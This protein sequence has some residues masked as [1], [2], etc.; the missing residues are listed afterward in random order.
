MDRQRIKSTSR[1]SATCSDVVLRGG[2]ETDS[3][4]LVFRPELVDNPHDNNAAVRG[5]FIYQ[6]K[7]KAKE[8]EDTREASLASLKSGEGY[9]LEL[10]AAEVFKLCGYLNELYKIFKKDGIPYGETE[11]VRLDSVVGQ[12]VQIPHP[13]LKA[14]LTAHQAMGEELLASLLVWAADAEDPAPLISRLIA[15]GESALRNLN[16]ATGLGTLKTALAIW[17]ENKLNSQEEF[18]QK[19]LTEHSFVL[20]QVFSWPMTIVKEKAY[21]GGKTV[22]NEGGNIVDFLVKNFLTKNAA[23][24]EIKTPNTA[25]LGRKYRNTFNLSEDLSGSV[26]QVLNYRSSLQRHYANIATGRARYE[27]F[28][29]KCV[30]IIG[31]VGAI[32]NDP[33]KI[34]ALELYRSSC[35]SVTV[36]T[37]DEL[38]AKTERLITV[39]ETA[40]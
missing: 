2:K 25:L 9:K 13:Q 38:F 39:L 23:L 22:L 4:R 35:S 20:E 6:K 17:K 36:I 11:Y 27:A 32:R 18:W 3:I 16:V 24:V 40:T 1:S 12:L 21:V 7:G 19:S 8:W 33:D 29:P 37:F 26:M 31:N 30:L 5:T 14:Y 10:H 34:A 28:E 15:L